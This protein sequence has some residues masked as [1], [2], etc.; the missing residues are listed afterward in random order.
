MENEVLHPAEGDVGTRLDAFIAAHFAVSRSRAQKILE[1]TLVNGKTAK[2][3]YTLRAGDKIVGAHYTPE[4]EIAPD[5]TP[6][7]EIPPI[8]YEDEDL[9]V[10]HKPRGLTVHPGAGDT[11]FTL[12]E[13]MQS[14]GRKLSNVG[15][16]ERAGIVHRLDRDTSGV[17]LIAKTD[18]AHWKLA[19]DFESREISKTYA[20]VCCG[21]P[22]ARG[23][24]EAPIT[25]SLS[26]RTKMTIAPSGRHAVTEYEIERQWERFALLKINLLTGR[27]H[28]IRVHFGYL[29][30]PIAGDIVYGGFYRALTNAPSDEVK[31]AIE[32]LRGQALHA[33]RIEFNHPING[34]KLSFEAPPPSEIAALIIALDAAK[35]AEEE[36]KAAPKPRHLP[37]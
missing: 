6:Q 27:T 36:E 22:P 2:P 21:I 14:H 34:Q 24:I 37:F 29:H 33:A 17:M 30:H 5:L 25:R 23:R 28:Q 20:A 8:L 7:G 32:N 1:N 26:N 11:G 3:S 4:A 16:P 9:M 15:P 10:I 19:A 12:V 13:I 35:Q 18:A 31:T